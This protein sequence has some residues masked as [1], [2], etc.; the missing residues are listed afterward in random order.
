MRLQFSSIAMITDC[1]EEK[2]QIQLKTKQ[3]VV[4]VVYTVCTC[5]ADSVEKAGKQN[6]EPTVRQ[7]FMVFMVYQNTNG[8]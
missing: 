4:F 1:T 5:I 6:I 8:I 3:L 2:N 7:N